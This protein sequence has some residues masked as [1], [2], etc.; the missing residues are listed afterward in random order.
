MEIIRDHRHAKAWQGQA[1]P[2]N[3]GP[4]SPLWHT[5][6]KLYERMILNRIAPIVEKHII[7]EQVGFSSGKSCTSQLLNLIQHIEYGY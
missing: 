2:E 1:I 3:Y 4:I 6:H 7:K 5:Y